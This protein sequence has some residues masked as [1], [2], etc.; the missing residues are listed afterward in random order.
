MQ[1]LT[2]SLLS[3]FHGI[4]PSFA[5]TSN[6]TANSIRNSKYTSAYAKQ[7]KEGIWIVHKFIWNLNWLIVLGLNRTFSIMFDL[8]F[9]TKVGYVV[10]TYI[11]SYN[12]NSLLIQIKTPLVFYT[13][14]HPCR[15]S[16]PTPSR[17]TA[18]DGY[19]TYA[20]AKTKREV[21]IGKVSS[22]KLA[23]ILCG[24]GK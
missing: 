4:T 9:R 21:S 14:G 11:P 24:N 6:A 16:V 17:Y 19:C 5:Q 18:S 3:Q 2:N 7:F 15:R 12:L 10:T 13:K 23:A 22:R 20:I 1:I 8:C